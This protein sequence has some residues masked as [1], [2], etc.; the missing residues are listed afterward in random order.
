MPLLVNAASRK[1]LSWAAPAAIGSV[2]DQKP[3]GNP[4]S[5]KAK[6][7]SSPHQT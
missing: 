3:E 5:W 1:A 4:R 7:E 6:L 2:L